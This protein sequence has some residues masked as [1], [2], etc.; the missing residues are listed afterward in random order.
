MQDVLYDLPLGKSRV[1]QAY[2]ADGHG[3]Q[4]DGAPNQ[5]RHLAV[6][7]PKIPLRSA[8]GS[9]R[10]LIHLIPKYAGPQPGNEFQAATKE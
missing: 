6:R 9:V 5:E 8:S 7:I 2:D 10:F 3:D 1:S 4:E